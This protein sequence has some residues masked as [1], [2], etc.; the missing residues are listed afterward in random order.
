MWGC[1]DA[2]FKPI[3]NV[4]T[5]RCLSAL[6]HRALDGSF[7]VPASKRVTA[8][9]IGLALTIAQ[10]IQIFFAHPKMM[11]YFVQNGRADLP[12]EVVLAVR[13]EFNILL[14]DVDDR[15]ANAG[16]L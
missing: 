4:S 7:Q 12:H 6:P 1:D 9:F 5:T 16:M 8:N 2:D 13:C 15:R 11:A 10:P 3:R 14:K